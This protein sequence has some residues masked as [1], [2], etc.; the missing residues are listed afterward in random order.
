MRH[1]RARMALA[2]GALRDRHERWVWDALDAGSV[3]R[4]D[5]AGR[6]TRERSSSAKDEDSRSSRLKPTVMPS[7]SVSRARM[8][9]S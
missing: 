7:L 8:N 3:G 6:F 5:I 1:S 4:D 9:A 2:R